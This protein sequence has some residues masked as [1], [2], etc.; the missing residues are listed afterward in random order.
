M[1]STSTIRS[2]WSVNGGSLVTNLVLGGYVEEGGIWWL[3][4]GSWFIIFGDVLT[5]T[6]TSILLWS[7]PGGWSLRFGRGDEIRL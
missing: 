4:A 7:L 1:A 2:L 3:V 6:V 5:S